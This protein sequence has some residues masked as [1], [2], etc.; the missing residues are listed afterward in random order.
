MH[1]QIG[2]KIKFILLAIISIPAFI[3]Y[4]VVLIDSELLSGLTYGWAIY[5]CLV[6]VII[7]AING[8]RFYANILAVAALI[9][10]PVVF[11][12]GFI[13]Y[14]IFLLGIG[15]A[16]GQ[17]AYSPHYVSVCV[18][19]LTVI[20]LSLSLVGVVPFQR[21]E[22]K[23]LQ[24]KAGVTKLEKGILMFLRVFNHIVYFVI[25][26]I[27]ETIREERHYR[28]WMATEAKTS[29]QF[30]DSRG[31]LQIK[32]KISTLKTGMIQLAVEGIC[33]SIQYI[34]LWAVEIS[35]LSDKSVRHYSAKP[36]K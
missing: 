32:N 34:P 26:D 2:W 27:L 5:F 29:S 17:S 7:P 21:F 36:Q 1:L 11:V 24:H 16:S 9:C 35:R 12:G 10:M 14:L 23:L 4:P 33:A 3:G 6:H 30:S 28:K 13:C 15:Y 19:M 8:T 22:H 20:P 18:T 25:P 31:I